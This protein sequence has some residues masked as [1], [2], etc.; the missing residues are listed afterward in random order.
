[1]PAAEPS[2]DDAFERAKA[3]GERQL[4]TAAQGKIDKLKPRQPR[5][6][7]AGQIDDA[8]KAANAAADGATDGAAAA[9]ADEQPKPKPPWLVSAEA[10]LTKSWTVELVYNGRAGR[11]YPQERKRKRLH[12]SDEDD[13]STSDLE[14]EAARAAPQPAVKGK[15]TGVR[16]TRKKCAFKRLC[17]QLGCE[18]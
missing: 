3:S 4:R 15:G 7:K 5:K 12:E 16:R 18:V 8:V 17:T 2:V 11:D 14:D 1:M 13:D 10:G 6:K 9:T